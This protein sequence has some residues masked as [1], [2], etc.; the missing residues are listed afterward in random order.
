V[1]HT[2]EDISR[3][4]AAKAKSVVKIE[5]E[6]PNYRGGEVVEIVRTQYLEIS[7]NLQT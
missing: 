6:D 4:F 7:V 5:A 3:Q 2:A 1:A